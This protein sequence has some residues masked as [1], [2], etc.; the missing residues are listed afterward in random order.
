MNPILSMSWTPAFRCILCLRDKHSRRAGLFPRMA[1]TF[2]GRAFIL[3]RHNSANA[4]K[5]KTLHTFHPRH[6]WTPDYDSPLNARAIVSL[7]NVCHV[8]QRTQ[9]CAV[10][11][12]QIER[13]EQ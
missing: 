7:P 12:P 5:P 8:L 10:D 1:L 3:R 9:K 4:A 13:K 2:L 11:R 6:H